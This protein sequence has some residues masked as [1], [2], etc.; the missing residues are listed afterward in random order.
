MSI[1]GNNFNNP[2]RRTIINGSGMS[3]RDIILSAF[4]RK[5]DLTLADAQKVITGHPQGIPPKKSA[6]LNVEIS[7]EYGD[8]DTFQTVYESMA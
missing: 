3:D 6:N 7:R 5:A 4:A 1:H 8:L 2:A